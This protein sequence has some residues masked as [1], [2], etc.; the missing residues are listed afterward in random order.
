MVADGSGKRILHASEEG[1][2]TTPE[3]V[4][5]QLAQKM[6]EMGASKFIAEV[7]A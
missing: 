4:G 6:L 2:A 5:N 3:L 7:R 1:S